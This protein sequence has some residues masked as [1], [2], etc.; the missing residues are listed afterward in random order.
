VIYL[1]ITFEGDSQRSFSFPSA[2]LAS[3]VAVKLMETIVKDGA[4][5][6]RWGENMTRYAV[7]DASRIILV[8]TEIPPMVAEG[9]VQA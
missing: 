7:V 9:E 8:D 2:E 6:F 5:G 4:T 1:T 3:A